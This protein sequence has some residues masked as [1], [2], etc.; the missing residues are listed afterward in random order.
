MIEFLN[1]HNFDHPISPK[2]LTKTTNKDYHNIILFLFQM[3]DPNYQCTGK[4][5]DEVVTMFKFLGYPYPIAKSNISAVGSP[6]AWPTMLASI[7]WLIELL[8]YAEA[9]GIGD[10]NPPPSSA[11]SGHDGF[12]EGTDIDDPSASEKAF[13]RYLG[14]AYG[15]FLSGKDDQYAVL[16]QQFIQSFENKNILIRDQIEA[17]EKKT[18]NLA[19]EIEEVKRRS[20]T[21]PELESK[22]KDALRQ[23]HRLQQ[24]VE[25][26]KKLKESLKVKID[27]RKT[28][29]EKTKNENSSLNKEIAVLKDRIASQEISPEDVLNMINERER[30][31]EAQCVASEHRQVLQRKIWECEMSLRDKVQALEDTV[32]AYHSIAEDLKMVPQS[33]RNARG[34]N[35]SIDLDIRAKR[36][37]GLLKTAVKKT[38][39]PV[40]QDVKKELNDTTLELRAEL[41]GEQDSL[42]EIQSQHQELKEA[43]DSYEVKLRRAEAAYKREKESLDQS[44]EIQSRELDAME[45]RLLQLRDTTTEEVK[46]NSATRRIAEVQAT[47]T[48][49]QSEHQ[50]KRTEMIEAIMD[51][52]SLAANHREVVQTKLEDL[53]A[54]YSQRLQQFLNGEELN[55]DKYQRI[56]TQIFQAPMTTAASSSSS[57]SSSSAAMVSLRNHPNFSRCKPAHFSS[58]PSSSKAWSGNRSQ[59]SESARDADEHFHLLSLRSSNGVPADNEI[60]D[61]VRFEDEDLS[62][63]HHPVVTVRN[64]LHFVM[65]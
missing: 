32:R 22:R 24:E 19:N 44:N 18:Q 38:I 37:E 49:R 61:S 14:K 26:A 10:F 34:E 31:E 4:I 1:E 62:P 20:A 15:L 39:L 54:N 23:Q 40:L 5:E 21:I 65:I 28:E 27:G 47:R 53:K 64:K 52:V 3:I 17:F 33:A 58:V 41:M 35:L 60:N 6:H 56:A 12:S 11:A 13:Y 29:I 16:E 50:R 43:F 9:S 36:R 2:I 51:V 45:S 57:S 48:A 7:M 8:N 25:E 55:I 46:I 59:A 30:L 42:A 63:I